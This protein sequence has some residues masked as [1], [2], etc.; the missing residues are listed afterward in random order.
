MLCN[1]GF[2]VGK[3]LYFK[4][5]SC[6][7]FPAWILKAS[8]VWTNTV[9]IC[10]IVYFCILF[11]ITFYLIYNDLRLVCLPFS[12]S[13]LFVWS[14]ALIIKFWTCFDTII[15]IALESKWLTWPSK[16]RI[17]LLKGSR[18]IFPHRSNSLVLICN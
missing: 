16:K 2:A 10:R 1:V 6:I 14:P 12:F 9:C 17:L 3:C 15:S 7:Y 18:S 13:W 4:Y 5:I 11:H 8:Y